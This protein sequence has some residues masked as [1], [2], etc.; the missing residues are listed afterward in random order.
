MT[1]DASCVIPADGSEHYVVLHGT[2]PTNQYDCDITADLVWTGMI[3]YARE[4]QVMDQVEQALI[5]ACTLHDNRYFREVSL[6]KVEST[7]DLVRPVFVNVSTDDN[8]RPMVDSHMAKVVGR[9][10]QMAAMLLIKDM[11][12]AARTSTTGG[13]DYMSIMRSY[14]SHQESIMTRMSRWL[15][16]VDILS[17]TGE[18]KWL[19]CMNNDDILDI[20]GL[21]IFEGLWLASSDCRSIENGG[22]DMLFK[23]KNDRLANNEYI[24][25]FQDE[26]AKIGIQFSVDRIP[27]G[28]FSVK[29]RCIFSD[30]DWSGWDCEEEEFED[31]IVFGCDDI[32]QTPIVEIPRQRSVKIPPGA[33]IIHRP[34]SMQVDKETERL[35]NIERQVKL[36]TERA[37][38]V[39]EENKRNA[40]AE[41]IRRMEE[42]RKKEREKRNSNPLPS[43]VRLPF[44]PPRQR[45]VVK[46]VRSE[47]L[48]RVQYGEDWSTTR[49]EMDMEED[50]E[51]VVEGAKEVS[52]RTDVDTEE[53]REVASEVS[54]SPQQMREFITMG[55]KVLDFS[56]LGPDLT[57]ENLLYEDPEKNFEL[58]R[59]RGRPHT[60]RHKRQYADVMN[61]HALDMAKTDP[62]NYDWFVDINWDVSLLDSL[63]GSPGWRMTLK[64]RGFHVDEPICNDGIDFYMMHLAK[65]G[66]SWN[67]MKVIDKLF[68]GTTVYMDPEVVLGTIRRHP[69]EAL[70]RKEMKK[71]DSS[72]ST[73]LK[74]ED[75]IFLGCAL[76]DDEFRA[77]ITSTQMKRL[78][79]WFHLTKIERGMLRRVTLDV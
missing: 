29:P 1:S 78:I 11:I 54:S 27:P 59:A 31:Q 47:P 14:L 40:I 71:A 25:L 9:V 10:H 19:S 61:A 18:M 70:V 57:E 49:P 51:A 39:Q 2:R 63:W 68:S 62:K 8:L 26:L 24:N 41:E 33:R 30:E 22:V 48:G 17:A 28:W 55:N 53:V 7:L 23:G 36:A 5:C 56:N 52:P 3:N 76:V 43:G 35:R 6:P 69:E 12:I 67:E 60:D 65:S 72:S 79:N 45:T 32:S 66:A 64:H 15:T 58:I 37:I 34:K 44:T 16:T 73:K 77:A 4:M 46:D 74:Q 50:L 75:G 13:Q 42:Q 20:G 21:S 38:T